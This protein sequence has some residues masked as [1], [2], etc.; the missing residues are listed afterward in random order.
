LFPPSR[1]A[2]CKEVEVKTK[3]DYLDATTN[4]REVY[5]GK[6]DDELL[7]LAVKRNSLSEGARYAFDAEMWSRGFLQGDLA[8]LAA[9]GSE[10]TKCTEVAC[11]QVKEET[12]RPSKLLRVLG[13]LFR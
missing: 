3:Q 4:F 9:E 5:W 12:N 6:T 7:R 10:K 13:I 8:R 2:F 11:G 1:T